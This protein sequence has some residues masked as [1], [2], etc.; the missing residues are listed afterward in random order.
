MLLP[1]FS[2]NGFRLTI[3]TRDEK[4]H[5]PHCHVRY[6]SAVVRIHL[7]AGLEAYGETRLTKKDIAR[8]RKIVAENYDRLLKMWNDLVES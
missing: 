6:G 3:Y 2:V 1:S 5:R 4:G 7:E 8:A